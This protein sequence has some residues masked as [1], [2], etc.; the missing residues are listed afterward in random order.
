MPSMTLNVS[1]QI[2]VQQLLVSVIVNMCICVDI[3]RPENF[4][5]AK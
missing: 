2:S 3:K 1:K 5:N 4:I